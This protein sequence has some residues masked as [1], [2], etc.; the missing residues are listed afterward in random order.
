MNE[1]ETIA[2]IHKG[3]DDLLMVSKNMKV[4]GPCFLRIDIQEG[5]PADYGF[6]MEKKS[7][8]R[9]EIQVKRK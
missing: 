7:C 2:A 3:L 5:R 4:T 1:T 6:I 9:R 8:I